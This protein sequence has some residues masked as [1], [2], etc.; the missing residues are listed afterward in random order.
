MFLP[1][2]LFVFQNEV[3][4]I[5]VSLTVVIADV[6]TGHLRTTYV[7]LSWGAQHL[8][9]PSVLLPTV[10][11]SFIWSPPSMSVWLRRSLVA[12]ACAVHSL[13]GA[14]WPH[15][16]RFFC[17]LHTFHSEGPGLIYAGIFGPRC[18]RTNENRSRTGF[19]ILAE[20]L[21]PQPDLSPS[22]KWPVKILPGPGTAQ[23]FFVG[24]GGALDHVQIFRPSE[25][26]TAL[27]YAPGGVFWYFGPNVGL[28]CPPR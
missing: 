25:M 3:S 10:V 12:C 1:H 13:T 2:S 16:R 27:W 5:A 14:L 6:R 7:F 8:P 4:L 26:T 11:S 18:S 23:R 21:S 28:W 19:R 15:G 20:Y 22:L 9:I 24:G 17:F